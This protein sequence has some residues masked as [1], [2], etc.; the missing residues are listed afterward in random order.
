MMSFCRG[1]VGRLAWV[2]G[3]ALIVVTLTGV[4]SASV[5]GRATYT[6]IP[7]T[8]RGLDYSQ[9]TQKP[10]RNARVLLVDNATDR[11]LEETV[12]GNDGSFVFEA[13]GGGRRKVIIVA[14]TLNP[15]IRVED[16]TD[17]DAVWAVDSPSFDG[18]TTLELVVPSGWGGRSYTG[19]RLSAPFAILDAAYSAAR[20]F[21]AVRPLNFPKL[22]I[23][24]SENNRPEEGENRNGQ[25]G[26]SHWD[27]K[28]LYIL[29]KEDVDTDEFD[30][31]VIVHEWGHYF[32]EKVSRSD[33]IG[34]SHGTGTILDPRLAFSE[35]FSDAVSAIVLFPNTVYTDSAG[36]G[37][38]RLAVATDL[39][40]NGDDPKPGWFS[41]ASVGLILF[42]L[43]DS[44]PDRADSISL[45]LGPIADVMTGHHKRTTAF[46]TI[47][48]FVKGLNDASPGSI[49][50]I[51]QLLVQH[52]MIP[53]RDSFG[54]GESNSG[55]SSANLPVYR[56]G[57]ING[58][59]LKLRLLGDQAENR[60][61]QN[62]YISFEGN[63]SQVTVSATT[64]EDVW[65]GVFQVGKLKGFS[66]SFF[67]GTEEVSL[68]A[69]AGNVYVIS[70][71][72]FRTDG[73]YDCT[74]RITSR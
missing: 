62:R 63:G 38:Q 44:N 45:G 13:S 71:G 60:L 65:L 57:K 54:T 22:S 17:G 48:S 29:G 73:N 55:G 68:T 33:S 26:S 4:A 61:G 39:E 36:P 3:C 51:D 72:G 35:G 6:S 41:G 10:I 23:N 16:N 37:Q 1:L 31:H 53:I 5:S 18:S 69:I 12:T 70:I 7:S 59:D 34:G 47:F 49:G 64:N 21:R 14:E 20:A 25:I 32:E 74:V 28:E 67:A 27:R 15:R 11:V 58:R 52:K 43:F 30:S 50:S 56:I 8:R 19:P 42:D 40:D 24:W 66:D 9:A 46:T 2:H